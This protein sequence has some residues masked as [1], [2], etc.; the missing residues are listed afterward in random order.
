MR[1]GAECRVRMSL[2]LGKPIGVMLVLALVGGL[3][4]A[5][6]GGGPERH[7]DDL[8][9][10]VSAPQHKETY[11]SLVEQFRQRTGKGVHVEYMATRSL[12]VRLLSLLMSGSRDVP[13]VVE[14]EIGGVG[15]YFRLPVADV[16]F[17]P[18]ND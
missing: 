9:L 1:P 14:I 12:D 15:K 18:L 10:W 4:V 2:Q 17:L 7:K 11:T 8:V 6:R 5:L 13:D 16:G 3:G